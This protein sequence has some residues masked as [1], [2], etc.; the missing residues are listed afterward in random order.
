MTLHSVKFWIRTLLI[1]F[2]LLTLGGEAFARA[3][4]KRSFGQ[5]SHP[6]V[7]PRSPNP[8]PQQQPMAQPAP[9]RGSFMR[10]LAGGLAGGLLGSMLFSSFGH[11]AGP[12]GF[13]GGGIGFLDII[14]IAGLLYLAFRLWKNRQNRPLSYAGAAP[15]MASSSNYQ[16][17]SSPAAAGYFGQ[18]LNSYASAPYS[19]GLSRDTAEEIF[20]RVQGAWTRRDLNLVQ[21]SVESEVLR[22][23]DQDLQQLKNRHE[24]NRL[25]NISVRQVEISEPWWD[26]GRE[27]TRVRFTASLLDYTVDEASGAVKEGSASEPVKFDEYWIF[28]KSQDQSRWRLAGIEQV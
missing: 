27:L 11:A 21:D 26:G 8:P 9:N 23:L 14:L 17:T 3:G 22:V 10:G 6:T 20:F 7:Q 13:G 16:A 28:A 15:G 25:E 4:S 19:V 1:T 18:G 24:I 5:R 2:G 12:G